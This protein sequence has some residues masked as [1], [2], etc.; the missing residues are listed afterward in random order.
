M[1]HLYSRSSPSAVRH[2]T[3]DAS[4][5]TNTPK[6]WQRLHHQ[7]DPP[8]ELSFLQSDSGLTG[9]VRA[10]PRKG[11]VRFLLGCLGPERPWGCKP[12]KALGLRALKRETPQSGARLERALNPPP[13]LLQT[14]CQTAFH[15]AE[16]GLPTA[17]RGT[18]SPKR[19]VCFGAWEAS[20][21]PSNQPALAWEPRPTA[22]INNGPNRSPNQDLPRCWLGPDADYAFTRSRHP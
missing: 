15:R 9:L 18:P 12:W 7:Q 3:D 5:G 13:Q 16:L 20:A 14:E 6:P 11:W 1:H 8:A 4:N 10:L 2:A 17:A 22:R 19:A 21:S